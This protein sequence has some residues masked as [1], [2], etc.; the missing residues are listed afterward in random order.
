MNILNDDE[1]PFLHMAS[2]QI[3]EPNIY[4]DGQQWQLKPNRTTKVNIFDDG[5]NELQ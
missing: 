3:N 5:D 2:I 1:L 4:Y